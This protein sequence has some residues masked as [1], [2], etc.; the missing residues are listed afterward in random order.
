[1]VILDDE[2]KVVTPAVQKQVH[3][4]GLCMFVDVVERLLRNPVEVRFDFRSKANFFQTGSV[5]FSFDVEMLRPFLEEIG[6]GY[7]QPEII[8]RGWAHLPREKLYVRV[9]TASNLLQLVDLF[10]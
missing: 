3:A 4:A 10:F 9:E 8:E 7:H 6:Y 1:T 5:K 2:R